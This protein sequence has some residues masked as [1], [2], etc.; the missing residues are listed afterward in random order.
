MVTPLVGVINITGWVEKSR[1]LFVRYR[2]DPT[3]DGFFA[4]FV[5]DGDGV[6]TVVM[7]NTVVPC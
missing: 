3:H 5:N 7:F 2:F 4:V 6:A 1:T